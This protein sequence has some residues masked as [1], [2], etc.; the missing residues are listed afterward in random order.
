[1]ANRVK[2]FL[3]DKIQ[4]ILFYLVAIST[5]G[6]I[7]S[8][9]TSGIFNPIISFLIVDVLLGHHFESKIEYKKLSYSLKEK[10]NSEYYDLYW[11]YSLRMIRTMF[12]LFMTLVYLAHSLFKLELLQLLVIDAGCLLFAIV[13]IGIICTVFGDYKKIRK[14]IDK[15]KQDYFFE[16][17]SDD[18]VII[19]GLKYRLV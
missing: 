2:N 8:M 1:M 4:F 17:D 15:R 10:F 12:G 6:V 13:A 7:V 9:L 3:I 5:F 19:N 16:F 14:L 11:N 18:V